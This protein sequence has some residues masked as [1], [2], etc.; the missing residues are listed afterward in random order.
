[1]V[2]M[3]DFHSE[4]LRVSLVYP[5]TLHQRQDTVTGHFSDSKLDRPVLQN[6]SLNLPLQLTEIADLSS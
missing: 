5:F 3:V 4:D 2:G 6:L 1:M